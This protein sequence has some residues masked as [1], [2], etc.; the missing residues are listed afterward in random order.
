LFLCLLLHGLHEGRL[1]LL[2]LDVLAIFGGTL[3]SVIHTYRF[4]M[5]YYIYFGDCRRT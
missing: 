1:D 2:V 3:L 5:A 4:G